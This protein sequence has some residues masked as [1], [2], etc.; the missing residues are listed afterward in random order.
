MRNSVDI[1][2]K[3]QFGYM[4]LQHFL[5][6]LVA[7]VFEALAFWYFLDKQ[8]GRQIVACVFTVVYGFGLYSASRKLS[9][10]DSKPYTPLQPRL[11]WGFLWGLAITATVALML[12]VYKFNWHAFSAVDE[13]G[14]RYLTSLP[15]V[16]L[17]LLFYLWTAP[18]FGFV[19]NQG[20]GIE[21]YGQ[22]LMLIVPPIATTL[23]YKAGMTNFDLLEKLDSM[24]L[25]KNTEEER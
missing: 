19:Q 24:T 15:A 4:I 11:K 13:N 9:V 5:I 8:I 22:I 17:N 25:E 3:Y 12:T 14:V 20:G 21:I 1:T 7:I 16:L 18:Y 23:G 6:A 10:W 2:R